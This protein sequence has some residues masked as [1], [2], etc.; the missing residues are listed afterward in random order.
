MDEMATARFELEAV[1]C[2]MAA[3]HIDAGS[4][5]DLRKEIAHQRNPAISDEDFCAS[6]VRFHRILVQASR[7]PVLRFVMNSV[8]EALMPVSN[9][10]IVRVRD[11]RTIAASHERMVDA[12]EQRDGESAVSALNELVAYIRGQYELA[13]QKRAERPSKARPNNQRA[14]G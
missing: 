5:A 2:R 13:E 1:C 9:M 7:N 6:D 8:V 3:V 4:I 10:I 11:R 14:V 12:L